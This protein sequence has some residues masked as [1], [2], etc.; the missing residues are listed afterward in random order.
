MRGMTTD[1]TI[2]ERVAWYRQR[3][4]ISQEVLAGRVDRT[5]DWV[6]KIENGRIELDRLSVL[7]TVAAALDVALGDLMAEPSLMEWTQDSGQ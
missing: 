7:R 4:G 1:L 5:A 6:S 2:G 3:R